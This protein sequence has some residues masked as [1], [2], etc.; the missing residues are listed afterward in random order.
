MAAGE[1]GD[2]QLL[3]DL[4]LADDDLG[5]LLEQVLV[6][7]DPPEPRASTHSDLAQL[8]QPP[9]QLRHQASV[10]IRWDRVELASH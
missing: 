7:A 6:Q 4:L 2:E 9:E 10:S 5:E 1:D 8:Q 3:Q